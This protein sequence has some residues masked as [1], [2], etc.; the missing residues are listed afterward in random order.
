MI[1]YLKRD[2]A[3]HGLFFNSAV[4]RERTAS[5]LQNSS[6]KDE[7]KLADKAALKFI[8]NMQKDYQKSRLVPELLLQVFMQCSTMALD[9]GLMLQGI[10]AQGRALGCRAA[11]FSPAPRLRR[12][13]DESQG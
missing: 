2:M 12:S 3:T 1:N 10:M 7:S 4:Q 8:V 6:T 9:T 11:A 13:Q 5:L